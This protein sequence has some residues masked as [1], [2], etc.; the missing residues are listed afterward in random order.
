MIKI[1]KGDITKVEADAIVNAANTTLQHQG[2]VAEAIVKA[3]GIV[4]QEESEKIGTV[5][6]GK[7]AVTSAGNLKAKVIIHIPTVD[8][9]S[10]RRATLEDIYIGAYEAFKKV[11]ELKLK[12]VALPLLGAGVVSLPKEDVMSQ[13]VFAAANFSELDITLVVKES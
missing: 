10:G 5:D 3:G 7:V 8:L 11:E 13:I 4:I 12:S 1:I 9:L 2:G 6:I